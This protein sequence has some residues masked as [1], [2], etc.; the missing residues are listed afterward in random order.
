EKCV[1]EL[2]AVANAQKNDCKGKNKYWNELTPP[3]TY[4]GFWR[5]R[6]IRPHLNKVTPA[7]MVVGG[8]FDAE[9]LYGPLN[10]YRTI[11]K[12]NPGAKNILVMGPW[13]HGQWA[14][15]NGDSLGAVGFGSNTSGWYREN[16]EL[17]FFNFYL[18]DQ[19]ESKL[20]EA[21][22]FLT[23]ANEWKSFD[24]WPPK[25]LQP[26]SIY[27]QEKGKLSFA[28]PPNSQGAGESFDEYV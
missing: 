6:N 2:G 23:G 28:P 3:G 26:L 14:R 27:F 17:P 5:R 12:N 10:I 1:G 19:G 21:T 24:Q 4:D 20:P 25:N 15:G 13:S 18:K 8:W 7:V 16:V 22:M 11:E 9:D